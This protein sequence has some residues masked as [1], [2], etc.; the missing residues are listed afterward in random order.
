MKKPITIIVIVV[1]V[2]ALAVLVWVADL[3]REAYLDKTLNHGESNLYALTTVVVEVD[4]DN[5]TVTCEDDT[6]NLWEFYGV[7]DWKIG[8]CASLLMN[9]QGTPSIYDDAIEGARYSAWTLTR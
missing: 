7:E 5:D 9:D 1:V 2:L 8:D 4:R 3:H 6:G